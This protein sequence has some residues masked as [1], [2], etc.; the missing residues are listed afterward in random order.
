MKALPVIAFL[1]AAAACGAVP[2]QIPT[3][4]SHALAQSTQAI[5]VTTPDWN[6]V[7]GRLQRFERP[8]VRAR[9]HAVGAP[10][11]IV[12]GRNG[13]GWGL[14]LEAADTPQLRSLGPV[15]KEGDIRSPA[16]IFAL[17]TAFGYA[18]QPLEGL[19]LPYLELT[20]TV[21]CVDDPASSHYNRIVD[22][23]QIAPDWKSSEHMRD[24]GEAY[25]WGIVVDHNAT[26]PGAA[27]PVPGSGSCVFLHIW[28]GDGRG[29]T[30]CTA[31]AEPNLEAL[32]IW[33]DPA[34]HPLLVQLPEPVYARLRRAWRLPRYGSL[35]AIASAK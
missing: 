20:P 21:E 26:V 15:K 7:E 28:S 5:V 17:G 4:R 34:R 12:V 8:G 16:G 2:A 19:K 10:I 29:T 23:A 14:G 30:G 1:A 13:L 33:L 11:A 9:W 18:A 22:R 32:M 31:M 25:V 35:P 3:P 6:A 27:P 24:A